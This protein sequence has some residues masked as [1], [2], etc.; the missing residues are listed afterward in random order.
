MAR[1]RSYYVILFFLLWIITNCYSDGSDKSSLPPPASQIDR[2]YSPCGANV[3]L[4]LA[5]GFLGQRESVS[6]AASWSVQPSLQGSW[7]WQTPRQK[8]HTHTD[9]PRHSVRSNRPHLCMHAFP[10]NAGNDASQPVWRR[11]TVILL[12][13]VFHHP[14]TLSL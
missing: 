8:Q 2:S 6:Q 3:N 14:L 13:L 10:C 11:H 4:H 12:L 5:R 1:V 7:P 9:R